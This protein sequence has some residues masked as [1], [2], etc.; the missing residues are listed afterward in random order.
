[1]PKLVLFL[2][3]K[4]NQVTLKCLH[5]PH[6]LALL[7]LVNRG[8]SAFLNA[9]GTWRRSGLLHLANEIVFYFQNFKTGSSDPRYIA[10]EPDLCDQSPLKNKI[11]ILGSPSQSGI[12]SAMLKMV[13]VV[14]EDHAKSSVM[15]F[16]EEDFAVE[17]EIASGGLSRLREILDPS[18]ALLNSGAVHNVRLRHRKI[19][20]YH[21]ALKM[22]GKVRKIG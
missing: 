2:V 15:L 4:T 11:K 16:L 22:C 13:N 8:K 7:I 5:K 14:S 19:R 9:L 10:L 17:E 18:I 12:S 1:M 20:G 21:S 3:A 6:H